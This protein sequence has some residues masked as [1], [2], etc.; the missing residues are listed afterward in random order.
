M[1]N[2][3]NLP[4]RTTSNVLLAKLSQLFLSKESSSVGSVLFLSYLDILRSF[5]QGPTL[6]PILFNISLNDLIFF[7]KETEVC[8][9]SDDTTIC[10]CSLNNKE[11][12]HQLSNDTYT[13]LNWFKANLEFPS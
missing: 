5:P 3:F 11:G 6:G 1:I 4:D 7:I 10:S 2:Y 8:N 13:I 9:F 12:A